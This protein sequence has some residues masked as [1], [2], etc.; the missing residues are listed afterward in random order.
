MVRR[1]RRRDPGLEQFWRRSIVERE[2]S[3]LSVRDHC[4]R[5]GVKEA[6]FYAW[7]REIAKRDWAKP[8][9]K[10]V[11]VHVRAEAVVE[12]VLSAGLT[13]RVPVGAEAT[14]VAQLVAALRAASC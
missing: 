3:G 8:A 12:I 5:H 10:F 2:R 6:N 7:R 9:L 4:V 14:S 13:V 11:P 1:T